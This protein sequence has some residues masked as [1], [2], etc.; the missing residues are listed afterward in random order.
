MMHLYTPLGLQAMSNVCEDKLRSTMQQ[1][2]KRS[3]S[4]D[5][6]TTNTRASIA[7]LS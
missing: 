1:Q 4:L 5:G 7:I 6:L 3:H 2:L